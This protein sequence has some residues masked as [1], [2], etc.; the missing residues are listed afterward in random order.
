[1]NGGGIEIVDLL[2]TQSAYLRQTAQLLVEEFREM[3]PDAWPTFEDGLQEV[4]DSLYPDRISRIALE[5]GAVVGWIGSAPQYNG[6][7]W[8]L[9]PLV[10]AKS[11]QRQGVGRRLVQDLEILVQQRGGRNLYVGTDDEAGFTSLA[12]I[13]LYP[14]PLNHLASIQNVK[15]HPFEFYQKMGFAIVGVIPDANGFGKPDIF[16]AKR[17][18][19]EGG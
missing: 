4:Q 17:I 5:S 18:G 15:G 2:P 6:H 14:D 1:M 11:H 12:G 16:M 7:T 13:D 19:T 10:V 8:E 3:A 9:H